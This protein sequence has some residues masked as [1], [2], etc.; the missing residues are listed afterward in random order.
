MNFSEQ[1]NLIENCK[2]KILLEHVFFGKQVH[3]CDQMHII[4]DDQRIGLILKNQAIFINKQNAKVTK[5][6]EN[7]FVIADD[8]LQITIIVNKL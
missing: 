5:H 8:R 3:Y 1:F 7:M 4:N 2:A 6:Y